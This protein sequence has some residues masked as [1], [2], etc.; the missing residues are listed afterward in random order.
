[1]NCC[2]YNDGANKLVF[3]ALGSYER[4]SVRQK[5]FLKYI[6]TGETQDDILLNNIDEKVK[7]INEDPGWRKQIMTLK[8]KIRDLNYYAREEGR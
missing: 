8:E 2:I 5:K 6:T 1:M 3:N 7:E 4:L